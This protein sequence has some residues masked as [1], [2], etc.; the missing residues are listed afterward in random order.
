MH[1]SWQSF[2]FN[3]KSS[4]HPFFDDYFT[5]LMLPASTPR[6]PSSSSRPSSRSKQAAA[7]SDQ[8]TP[9]SLSRTVP[10]SSIPSRL[11][12]GISRSYTAPQGGD[13]LRGRADRHEIQSGEYSEDE[14]EIQ[15]FVEE[16]TAEDGPKIAGIPRSATVLWLKSYGVRSQ[17]SV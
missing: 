14:G 2:L 6:P 13:D 4:K 15:G 17:K 16:V 5:P 7:P 8:H 3:A 1:P 10:Y 12:A 9:L 11:R